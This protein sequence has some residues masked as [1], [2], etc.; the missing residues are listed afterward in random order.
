VGNG[1]CLP[2]RKSGELRRV[3][4]SSCGGIRHES[5]LVRIA[6]ANLAAD[7]C[8]ADVESLARAGI[9]RQLLL[10]KVE[11]VVGAKDGPLRKQPMVLVG[12]L[13]AAANGDQSGVTLPW[14]D[15]HGLI[16]ARM[17]FR[18]GP[19]TAMHAPP[20]GMLASGPEG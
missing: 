2:G 16:L 7:P 3:G 15:W 10:E 18:K 20:R 1:H 8:A 19:A 14:Q 6:H 4:K 13:S 5:C 9:S 17:I 12:Q 11:D